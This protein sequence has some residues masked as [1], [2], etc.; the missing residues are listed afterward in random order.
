MANK[1]LR[2]KAKKMKRKNNPLAL[3][4]R[5]KRP[6]VSF[7]GTCLN[8]ETIGN[9][10]STA[11]AGYMS[12]CYPIDCSALSTTANQTMSYFQRNL[13][14]FYSEYWYRSVK[15]EWLPLVG[16]SDVNAA[17]QV[18]CCYFDNAEHISNFVGNAV[19]GALVN[20][21]VILS[22][23]GMRM[24]NAWEHVT[25]NLPITKRLKTFAV[26]QSMLYSDIQDVDRSTQGLFGFFIQSSTGTGVSMG[27]VRFTYCVELR[28]LVSS[29]T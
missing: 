13:T 8:G 1:S 23:R 9:N 7:D 2:A 16:P 25:F 20:R 18:Y 12:Y 27:R 6:Q 11:A 14:N 5:F 26:N 22:D 17:A 15:V 4:V 3:R 21:D 29:A 28:G 10:M 19:A 24:F